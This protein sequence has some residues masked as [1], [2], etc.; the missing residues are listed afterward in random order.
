MQP[1]SIMNTKQTTTAEVPS[2][3]TQSHT[4]MPFPRNFKYEPPHTRRRVESHTGRNTA[5]HPVAEGLSVRPT[6]SRVV[7]HTPKGLARH[8]EGLCETEGP[9]GPHLSSSS[10]AALARR[11]S[12]LL[13]IR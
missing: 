2:S 4:V 1:L 13:R 8:R 12:H 10:A 11:G 9:A 6:T 3:I 5:T 7:S